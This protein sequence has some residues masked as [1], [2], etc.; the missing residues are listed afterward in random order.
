M[1]LMREQNLKSFKLQIEDLE[2]D[3]PII[4]N[5]MLGVKLEKVNKV[6][7]GG[8]SENDEKKNKT[9]AFLDQLQKEKRDQLYEVYKHDFNMFEYDPYM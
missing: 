1:L 4:F 5:D 2:R 9:I 8:D 7:S 3:L 6:N